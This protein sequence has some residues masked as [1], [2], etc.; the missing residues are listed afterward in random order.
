MLEGKCS[1][2]C[3]SAFGSALMTPDPDISLKS[4][5]HTKWKVYL[6]IQ[7]GG[8]CHSNEKC[9]CVCVRVLDVP[10]GPLAENWRN[11]GEKR[12]KNRQHRKCDYCIRLQ[13]STVGGSLGPNIAHFCKNRQFLLFIGSDFQLEIQFWA[14]F[15]QYSF[16]QYFFGSLLYAMGGQGCC[17]SKPKL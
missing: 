8:V 13:K 17:N 12:A 4:I 10:S 5:C 9:V 6:V 11:I 3:T 14:I 2:K 7:T 1:L 16:Q 15:G